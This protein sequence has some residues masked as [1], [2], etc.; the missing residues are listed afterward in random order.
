MSIL[1]TTDFESGMV[2]ISQSQ[3]TSADLSEFITD[4]K[5]YQVIREILGY[6]LGQEL[7]DDLAGDP[8]VPQTN[9]WIAIWDE[10]TFNWEDISIHSYGMKEILKRL[11]YNEFEVYQRS[12]NS[13]AGESIVTQEASVTGTG[14]KRVRLFNQAID[15]IRALQLYVDDRSSIYSDFDGR[16]FEFDSLV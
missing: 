8:A 2:K 14:I 5:Q 12:I 3:Y 16:Y 1:K 6:T 13:A 10:F 9:E 15:S 4:E 7:I 11:V